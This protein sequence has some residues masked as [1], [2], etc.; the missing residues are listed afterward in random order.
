M[1][2]YNILHAR[3]SNQ[4]WE[5]IRESGGKLLSAPELADLRIEVVAR[6][7]EVL[8]DDADEFDF[9]RAVRNVD[10]FGFWS[11]R[12]TTS[13][14]LVRADDGYVIMHGLIID[15]SGVISDGGVIY[16]ISGISGGY[17][18][19]NP[20]SGGCYEVKDLIQHSVFRAL[21]GSEDRIRDYGDCLERLS[22][23][24]ISS[25]GRESIWTPQDLPVGYGRAFALGLG[26]DS[27]YPPNNTTSNHWAIVEV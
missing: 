17:F 23:A 25:V 18:E 24:R 16:D 15:P 21:M 10:T 27:I 1:S 26:G 20:N 7:L 13:S 9:L 22:R 12:F 5:K 11:E 14:H 2:K 6:V 4:L 8:S 19:Y 3:R